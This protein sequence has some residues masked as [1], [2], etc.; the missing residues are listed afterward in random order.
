V[1]S[2]ALIY[3][4]FLWNAAVTI[5]IP[6]CVTRARQKGN[7][8]FFFLFRCCI[9]GV[10]LFESRDADVDTDYRATHCYLHAMMRQNGTLRRCNHA[11]WGNKQSLSNNTTKMALEMTIEMLLIYNDFPF[12]S[13][14]VMDWTLI[15]AYNWSVYKIRQ[16]S[17]TGSVTAT[18]L[19]LICFCLLKTLYFVWRPNP[20]FPSLFFTLNCFVHFP[21]DH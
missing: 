19:K 6:C 21:A 18:F 14:E 13:C 15:K 8:S 1:R 3:R 16:H 2:Y 20:L 10:E 12:C 7:I 5:C 11:G 9:S 4:N 17:Q